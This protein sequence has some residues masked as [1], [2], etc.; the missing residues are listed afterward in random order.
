MSA[1]G[2]KLL[3]D[4]QEDV[5]FVT[6]AYADG[7]VAHLHVSWLEPHKGWSGSRDATRS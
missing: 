3:T 2:H 1:T 7:T 6:L 4:D 5:C